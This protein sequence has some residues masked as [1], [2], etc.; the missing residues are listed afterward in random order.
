MQT[1]EH[2]EELCAAASIGQ[3]S[4]EELFELERHTS[5][6]ERCCDA[7]AKYLGLA[8]QQFSLA[9]KDRK[10]TPKEAS[11]CLN[12]DRFTQRFFERAQEEGIHFSNDVEKEV[13]KV[14]PARVSFSRVSARWHQPRFAFAGLL[15]AAVFG[16]SGY[17]LYKH[18]LQTEVPPSSV[19]KNDHE[20]VAE[21]SSN[22]RIAELAREN[23]V[24]EAHVSDL[25]DQIRELNK[26]LRT[27]DANLA[28]ASADRKTLAADRDH[29]QAQLE[30]AQ[31]ALAE[32]QAAIASG[33]QE[34]TALRTHASDL[35]SNLVADE[36]RLHDVTQELAEKST[37]LDKEHQLLALNRD[38]SDLM[39]ARNLHIVDVVDIDARGKTQPAF[40]R[41]FFTEGKSLLFYAFDLNEAKLEKAKL[42]YR[43]WA[44]QETGDKKVRSLG[45][46]YSDDKTQRRWLFKCD[47]PKILNEIDSVFV[48]LEAP[49]ANP[50]HPKGA[51]LM[52]AYLRGQP[53]HP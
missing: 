28:A 15:I 44:K 34:I 38:V 21:D 31:R 42:E 41:I 22:Q 45:I 36:A 4:P 11:E 8:A 12:S 40:G 37:N 51:N 49:N 32:S 2:F 48:T 25:M 47:D 19:T 18:N 6:C 35:E 24:L 9:H 50:S 26:Q 30:D 43:I 27:S 10:L 23:A 13:V 14:T 29:M 17:R 39:G 33:R 7:Y 3:A 53:N 52:Y 5:T 16:V 46:F 20:A 1:H